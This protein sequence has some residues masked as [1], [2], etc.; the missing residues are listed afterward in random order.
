MFT[1]MSILRAVGNPILFRR[2]GGQ[3][4]SFVSLFPA[5]L[6][7]RLRNRQLNYLRFTLCNFYSTHSFVSGQDPGR[8]K[9]DSDCCLNY[10][11]AEIVC[12]IVTGHEIL[13][14]EDV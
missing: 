7:H 11:I 13:S 1:Q 4:H 3:T 12:W 6:D 5:H 8:N 10:L 9:T 2:F 14:V